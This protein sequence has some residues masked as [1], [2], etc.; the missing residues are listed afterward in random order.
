MRTFIAL[1]FAALV[2]ADEIHLAN[3]EIIDGEVLSEDA[4]SV[5][6]RIV[7][8]GMSA[9]RTW[10]KSEI[11]RIVRGESRRQRAAVAVRSEAAALTPD[12]PAAARTA[13]AVR[14]KQSGD[15]TLAR[16]LAEQAVARDRHQSEA[17]RLLGRELVAGVWM[18]PHEAAT[19]RGLV[20]HEGKW[21]T[22][23]E[24]ETKRAEERE[25]LER[26]R[27]A[28]AAA[29][30][31]RRDAAEVVDVGSYQLPLRWSYPAR[32]VWWGGYPGWQHGYPPVVGP[33]CNGNIP[34]S[35]I[36]MT[37]GWGNVDWRIRL[38]W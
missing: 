2:V 1:L 17:Q 20:W 29:M 36:N 15:A 27:A 38:T 16:T 34:Y 21:L 9:E 18:R 7:Q 32:T 24:R 26:Q 8:G 11:A 22:W 23:D 28:M 6:V 25:R 3:G 37:G 33:P 14:A 10:P 4:G 5:R 13:L 12:S 35:S 19:A 31:R 30:Q